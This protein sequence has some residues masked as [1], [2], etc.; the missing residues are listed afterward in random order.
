MKYKEIPAKISGIY[1]INYPNNKIYIGRAINIKRRIWEHYSKIDHTPSQHALWEYYTSYEDIDIDI[2]EQLSSYD[3]ETICNLEK[4]WIQFYNASNKEN[5]Y[6]LTDGGDG[7][8]NGVKN[9]ASKISQEDLDNII[10]LLQEQHTNVYISELYGLHPDTIGK[11]NQG[12]HYFNNNLNYPIRKG[13]GIINYKQKYN[14][15]SDEQLETALYLLST[16]QL[17]RKEIS[18]QTNISESTLTNLNTG[19]HPY[20]KQVNINFPIRKTRKTI[21]FTSVEIEQ[22]K[23]EL[24]NKNY[25]IQDIADHFNCSRDTISDINQ[26]KRYSKQEEKYPIRNFYPN[27]GSKK[28]VSTISG[29][30][31]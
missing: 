10:L 3:F 1:K 22:I 30:G 12:K 27:R 21:S 14:S 9:P 8:Q 31:E 26:G 23:Q 15:F 25:S 16:T 29:T 19:K 28:S 17:S 13:P 20:C 4:K 6:N 2:L 7:G 5:G 11:I 24:L 18:L